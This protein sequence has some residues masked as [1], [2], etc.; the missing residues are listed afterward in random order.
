LSASGIFFVLLGSAGEFE[1][2]REV[3]G[4]DDIL[5]KASQLQ[6]ILS[7]GCA[8]LD[9]LKKRSVSARDLHKTATI[10]LVGCRILP[11]I[12]SQQLS[13]NCE[14]PNRRPK[15]PFFVEKDLSALAWD[16]QASI[17]V[18]LGRRFLGCGS[19]FVPEGYSGG[20]RE[21]GRRRGVAR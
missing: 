17:D 20:S 3:R 18:F 7:N 11:R 6:T 10:R 19:F 21:P 14:G 12:A 2:E 1:G 4:V 8:A 13:D 15:P 9:Y 16:A 5:R